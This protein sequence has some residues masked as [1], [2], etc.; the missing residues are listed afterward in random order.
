[1]EDLWA[2]DGCGMT[3][4]FTEVDVHVKTTNRLPDGSLKAIEDVICWGALQVGG[5]AW[6]SL[7]FDGVHPMAAVIAKIKEGMP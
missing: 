6:Q 2:C 3:G 7:V 4:T 1:M 5:P